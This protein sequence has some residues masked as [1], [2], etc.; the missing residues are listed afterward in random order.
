M[1]CI[2]GMIDKEN[3]CAWIGG[4]SLGSNWTTKAINLQPKVFRNSIFKNVVMG[5]T[6]TFRHIDLLKYSDTLFPEIDF[7][8]KEEFNHKYMVTKF[9]PN[10]IKLFSE[11]I[12][13]E[14]DKDKGANLIICAGNH[15]FE[16]QDDYSVLEPALGFAAVGCGEYFAK[17]S[18]YSTR[19]LDIS[20]KERIA[21]AL[22]A[23]EQC[24]CGVQRP[25][26]I[27]N[28]KDEEVVTI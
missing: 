1:T 24:G 11:G 12:K 6:T 20:P 2:I 7:Y 15:V 17:G 19:M 28:T 9:I 10:L 16:V 13:S 4:D 3:D 26:T 5:S 22:E 14:N 18:L 27:L 21:I 25:F 8:K 23:A